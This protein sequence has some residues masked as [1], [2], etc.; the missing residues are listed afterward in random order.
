MRYTGL[1][2][3]TTPVALDRYHQLLRAQAPH[4][5]L[6][7]AVALT[8]AVRELAIAG[9]RQRHPGAPEQEI[10]VRLAVRLYGADAARRLFGQIP[11]DA[12]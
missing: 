2:Q 11:S 8:R 9:L 1:M 12:V 10:R 5:R 3:D 7:K 6:A 4:Q